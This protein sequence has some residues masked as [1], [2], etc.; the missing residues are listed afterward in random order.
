MKHQSGVVYTSWLFLWDTPCQTYDGCILYDLKFLRWMFRK[1]AFVVAPFQNVSKAISSW[2]EM[3]YHYHCEHQL[4]LTQASLMMRM[5][6]LIIMRMATFYF[7]TRQNE[8]QIGKPPLLL[9]LSPLFAQENTLLNPQGGA[10][11]WSKD[12]METKRHKAKCHTGWF[13]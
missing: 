4:S 12:I 9:L 6:C 1:Y 11:T 3:S 7:V 8:S 10:S 5:A 13:F 2:Q